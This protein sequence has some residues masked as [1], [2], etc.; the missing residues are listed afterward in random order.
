MS[1]DSERLLALIQAEREHLASGPAARTDAWLKL[2][3]AVDAG[4][5][6]PFDLP[7]SAVPSTLGAYS[8]V[9]VGLSAGTAAVLIAAG[10]WW[11]ANTPA[12][13]PVASPAPPPAPQVASSS[14]SSASVAP[15]P[16]T[17]PP[18]TPRTRRAPP[19]AAPPQVTP[20]PPPTKSSPE[21]GTLLEELRLLRRAQVHIKRGQLE[22]AVSVLEEHARR[23][24][25]GQVA[26]ERQAL[27]AIT[28]C[29]L[30]RPEGRE[31]AK[32]FLQAHPASPQAPRVKLACLDE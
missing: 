29:K 21:P 10:V 14:T 28:W 4:T 26:E 25:D 24:P 27:Q 5:A 30:G 31:A 1:H 22:E 13:V 7:W 9:T 11:A 12:P 17:P 20:P 19:K 23:F 8:L 3:A 32:A 6:A 18:K 2:S 15:P 16:A